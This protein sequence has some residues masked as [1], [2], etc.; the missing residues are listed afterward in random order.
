MGHSFF[1]L[2]VNIRVNGP[3]KSV[4]GLDWSWLNRLFS[5]RVPYWSDI[6]PASIR[7]GF[8]YLGDHCESSFVVVSFWFSLARQTRW[9]HRRLGRNA[10]AVIALN[11]LPNRD[12][13]LLKRM[14]GS[15]CF[16]NVAPQR[17]P[18]VNW[19]D[20]SFFFFLSF[21]C[22]AVSRFFVIQREFTAHQRASRVS[23]D[24]LMDSFHRRGLFLRL[25]HRKC[26]P[27][28]SARRHFAETFFAS[29]ASIRFAAS[30][31]WFGSLWSL[32]VD[33]WLDE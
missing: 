31:D 30:I 17:T 15:C 2:W 28:C 25:P 1:N 7:D 4:R 6:R 23:I 26:A 27:P 19:A 12:R 14:T 22:E 18:T 13:I 5:N 16:S 8:S 32:L 20:G 11:E 29:S 9:R 33:H 24:P 10:A 21:F 3:R